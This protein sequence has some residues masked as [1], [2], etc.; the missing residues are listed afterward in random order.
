VFII[1]QDT[2]TAATTIAPTSS[3]ISNTILEMP[4]LANIWL[5]TFLFIM[6]NLG[7]IGNVLVLQSQ[8]FR[9]R[10]Y[11]I[12]LFS[13]AISDFFL[14]NLVLLTRV[15]EKGFGIPVYDSSYV[16]IC[17]IR[18]TSAYYFQLTSFT[19]FS[20]ATID[21]ILSTQRSNCKYVDIYHSISSV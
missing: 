7:C 15:I 10:A 21:R 20:F 2:M 3:T 17:K 6:G 14:M 18:Q 16:S 9:N 19:L 11:T 13:E 12:Y 8:T 4:S 1:D 5:G